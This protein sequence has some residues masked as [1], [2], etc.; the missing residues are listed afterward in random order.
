MDWTTMGVQK[1]GGNMEL[2]DYELVDIVKIRTTEV[3]LF[4]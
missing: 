1:M 2:A 3:S 4:Y